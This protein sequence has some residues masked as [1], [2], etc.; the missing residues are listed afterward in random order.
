MN[1]FL[2]RVMQVR[3]SCMKIVVFNLLNLVMHAE[4]RY[5]C[6]WVEYKKKTVEPCISLY[7]IRGLDKCND[8]YISYNILNAFI[9]INIHVSV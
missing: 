7:A 6:K 1:L 8:F 2:V 4:L 3:D 5:I 9:L